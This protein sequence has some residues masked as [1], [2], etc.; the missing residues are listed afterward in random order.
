MKVRNSPTS[1]QSHIAEPYNRNLSHKPSNV[2]LQTPH[3]TMLYN[4]V[5]MKFGES[6]SGI[7][8][9]TFSASGI[10][11]KAINAMLRGKPDLSCFNQLKRAHA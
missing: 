7:D 3:H 4:C 2:T 6:F 8:L 10:E 9:R 11:E 1:M 5:A